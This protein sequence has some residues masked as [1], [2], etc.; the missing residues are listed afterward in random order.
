[1]IHKQTTIQG[2]S[3]SDVIS[4]F[5]WPN[6]DQNWVLT[7]SLIVKKNHKNY[8]LWNQTANNMY[9]FFYIFRS[10]FL[11][12]YELTF[13]IF[14]FYLPYTRFKNYSYIWW[15][16]LYTSFIFHTLYF[17]QT[18]LYIKLLFFLSYFIDFENFKI[19]LL[20]FSLIKLTKIS[21]FL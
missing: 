19:L 12:F 18:F 1:M 13:F 21:H 10:S 9:N 20:N 6:P 4:W 5:L 17:N 11:S 3:I 15:C 2:L 14:F 16:I 8:F 7:K